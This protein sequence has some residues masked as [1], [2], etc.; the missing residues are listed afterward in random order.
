MSQKDILIL[1]Q[2]DESGIYAGEEEEADIETRG[3][4]I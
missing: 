1:G 2:P 4:D 3:V